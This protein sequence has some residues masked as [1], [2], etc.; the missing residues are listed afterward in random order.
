M[1][2]RRYDEVHQ[3]ADGALAVLGVLF[4]KEPL[5]QR[6]AL[7]AVFS[8]I[9]FNLRCRGTGSG[10]LS[11]PAKLMSA[12][13]GREKPGGPVGGWAAK[14]RFAHTKW[15]KVKKKLGHP[16]VRGEP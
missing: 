12:L 3:A 11:L 2:S 15:V 5:T 1:V 13:L 14:K 4:G 9:L 6:T 16:A 7:R 10:S 8:L